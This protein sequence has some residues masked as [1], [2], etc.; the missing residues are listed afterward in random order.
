MSI[1]TSVLVKIDVAGNKTTSVFIKTNVVSDNRHWF[2]VRIDVVLL[3]TISIFT[4]IDVVN[5]T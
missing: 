2:L 4:K 5:E 3:P 1:L